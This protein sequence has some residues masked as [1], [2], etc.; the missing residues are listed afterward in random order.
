MICCLARDRRFTDED[1]ELLGAVANQ[2]AVGLKKAELIKRLTAENIVKDMFDALA[3]GS[4]EAAQAKASQARCDLAG[5]HL[6]LQVERAPRA[7]DPS[8]GWPELASRL[9]TR[10][11]RLYPRAFFDSRHD[12]VRALVLLPSTNGGAVEGMRVR[13]ASRWAARRGSSSASRTSIAAPPAPAGGCAKPP[14]RPAS[15]V[16]WSP[17]AAP[18]PTNSGG[19]YRDPVHLV[20]STR[21]PATAIASQSRI[22]AR[23][24]AATAP[25][26][27][28]RWSSSSPTAA[29]SAP[30][31]GR[32]TCTRIRSASDSTGPPGRQ[33]S[34]WPTK[35]CCHWSWR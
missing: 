17:A 7:D 31:R 14:M 20:F 13:M 26:W 22:W 23:T 16:R 27:W 21:R 4:I 11:R 12:R 30:A 8:A 9:E 1:A 33:S 5:P 32:S 24:T 15:G 35:T 3:A 19:A 29:A 6:F 25:G 10:L 18:S 28:K 2:T 34:S